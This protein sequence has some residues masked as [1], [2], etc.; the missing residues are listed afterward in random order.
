MDFKNAK[1]LIIDDQE[2]N[3]L[4]L[5]NFLELNGY[6]DY[7]VIND[8]RKAI[9]T[10]EFYRPD[11]ILLDIMMPFISGLEILELLSEKGLLDSPLRVMV[12]TADVT[13]ETLLNVLKSGANDILRKPFDLL[14]LELRI[15]NLLHSN[16]LLKR[17]ED[18]AYNLALIVEERTQELVQKNTEL[19]Q[20]IYVA[21]HDTQEP[22]RMITGFLKLLKD[23]YGDQLDGKAKEYIDFSVKSAERLKMLISELLVFSR[24][25]ADFSEQLEYV[26]LNEVINDVLTLLQRKIQDSEAA[27]KV[28]KLPIV[29]AVYM[30]MRQI[31]QN[32]ICNAIIYQ[33]ADQLPEIE[34]YAEMDEFETRIFVSDNGIGIAEEDQQKI[35]N[36]FT[37]LHRREEFEGSGL[38]LSLSK[39]LIEK[40]GG[41]ITIESD[42]G[43]GSRFCVHLPKKMQ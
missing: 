32:L 30:P 20:F 21:S 31:L 39:K 29:K 13:K 3:T 5:E 41:K 35:F 23:K 38:G 40:L 1:I 11:L 7:H 2:A 27:I 16:H 28:D 22:L 36:V 8:S 17:L 25:D 12:L 26:E 4:L 15:T 37:R 10:I 14:E 18:D 34:I 6:T 24:A 43:K 19:Q 9:E 33:P 42:L